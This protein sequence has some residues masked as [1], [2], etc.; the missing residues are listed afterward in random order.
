MNP[1]ASSLA[2]L[3][4]GIAFALLF[5]AGAVASLSSFFD[6]SRRLRDPGA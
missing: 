5:C 4:V 3:R 2:W 6:D 1:A